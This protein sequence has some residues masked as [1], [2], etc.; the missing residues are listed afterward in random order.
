MMFGIIE[1]DRTSDLSAS[2]RTLCN[3]SLR[4]RATVGGFVNCMPINQITTFPSSADFTVIIECV[5][6]MANYHL[7]YTMH[8]EHTHT[9][10]GARSQCTRIQ[11]SSL[12]I[13]TY[14]EEALTCIWTFSQITERRTLQRSLLIFLSNT[15]RYEHTQHC[16]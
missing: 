1:T 7:H 8:N 5:V 15:K 6:L 3:E 2:G 4:P 16:S 12:S 9:R 14:I 10:A 11:P 13:I